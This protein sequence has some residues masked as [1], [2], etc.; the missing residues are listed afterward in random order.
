MMTTSERNALSKALTLN[1]A[2]SVERV[3]FGV[4]RVPS[5]T[6]DGETYIVTVRDGQYRCDCPAHTYGRPCWHMA[7]VYLAKVQAKGAKVVGVNPATKAAAVMVL[8][9]E[10]MA[11]ATDTAQYAQ[12]A[13]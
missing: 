11:R 13:A 1:G 12:V 10:R 3:Q 6:S 2:A 4:Y 9:G 5:A 7:A 8:P